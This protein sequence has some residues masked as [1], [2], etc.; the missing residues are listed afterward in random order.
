MVCLTIFNRLL[1]ITLL[2]YSSSLIAAPSGEQ[3][4]QAC[5]YSLENNFEGIKG[6]MCIWYVTPCDCDPTKQTEAPRVCLPFE[7]DEN[8]LALK[9]IEGL[10]KDPELGKQDASVAAAIILAEYYPCE[11]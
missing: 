1:F 10:K 5:E 9:V 7:Q 6:Q 11:E 8:D 3:L 2:Y 4:Q